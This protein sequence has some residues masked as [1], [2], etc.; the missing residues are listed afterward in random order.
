MTPPAVSI[1]SVNGVTS[2][3]NKSL[4]S[5]AYSPPKIPP[6]TAA[7]YATA[8]SGLIFLFGSLP[9]KNSLISS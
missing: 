6:C 5:S 7:P 1:P 3:I 9:L 2:I 4:V 8:S